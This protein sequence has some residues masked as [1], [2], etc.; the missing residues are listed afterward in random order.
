MTGPRRR[1]LQALAQ[2]GHATPETLAAAVSG[3]GGGAVA[4][5]TIYRNLES[6]ATAGLVRH[7]HLDHG[8]PS[9]YL[10]EHGDHLHLVCRS[11][12]RV[13]SADPGLAAGL[14]RSLLQQDGFD[15]DVTHMAIHG[16]CSRCGPADERHR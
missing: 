4:P 3:D 11:C 6:L 7:S 14:A 16:Q 8:P 9:Y 10:A 12:G 13:T 5:S 2:L 1:V 15:A